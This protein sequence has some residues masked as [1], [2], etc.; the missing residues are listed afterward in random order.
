MIRLTEIAEA[1]YFN[2]AHGIKV[3]ISATL[4]IDIDLNEVKCLVVPVEG[5]FVPFFM[6][7]RG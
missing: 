3:E 6:G 1:G 5:I 2:K 7:F 4:D